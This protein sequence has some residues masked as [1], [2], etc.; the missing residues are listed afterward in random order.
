LPASIAGL[1]LSVPLSAA[2]FLSLNAVCISGFEE[3]NEEGMVETHEKVI[4]EIINA[5][6]RR[7]EQE[8]GC[9]E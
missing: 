7:D 1:C 6:V 4:M 8:D 2:L 9:G 3:Q 5:G